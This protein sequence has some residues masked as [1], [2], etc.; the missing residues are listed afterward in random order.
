MSH[1]VPLFMPGGPL[2]AEARVFG[3]LSKKWVIRIPGVSQ[4]NL[5]SFFCSRLVSKGRIGW[6]VICINNRVSVLRLPVT[7]SQ[8]VLL[9]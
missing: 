7:T 4:K 2:E 5:K 3:T 8:E 1:R 9:K 6:A